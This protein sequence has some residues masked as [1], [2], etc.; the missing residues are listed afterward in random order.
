[1][2]IR[3]RGPLE[4][5]PRAREAFLVYHWPGNI[6]ELK[7]CIE[8]AILLSNGRTIYPE[9]LPSDLRREDNPQ[10]FGTL[11]EVEAQHI[12][13]VLQSVNWNTRRAAEILGINRSTLYEKIR[14]NGIARPRERSASARDASNGEKG[15]SSNG[16]ATNG[17]GGNDLHPDDLESPA[18]AI[19]TESLLSRSEEST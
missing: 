17:A 18:E 14:T 9:N 10:P 12:G 13:R 4:L 3:D 19:E 2:C 6:R 16:N 7:N 15:P 1:M 5:S 11:A 8:E